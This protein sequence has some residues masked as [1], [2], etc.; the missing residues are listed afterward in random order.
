MLI[1]RINGNIFNRVKL[2]TCPISKGG[3]IVRISPVIL[4]MSVCCTNHHVSI[5]IVV[6]TV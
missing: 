5:Q 3:F 4:N 1:R 6:K 2:N